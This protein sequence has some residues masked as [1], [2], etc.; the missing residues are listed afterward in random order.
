MFTRPWSEHSTLH[1]ML[2]LLD[3]VSDALN[4]KKFTIAIFC[5]LRKAFDTC[6]HEILLGKLKR[7]GVDGPELDWFKSYLSGRRQFISVGGR[8]KSRL[9]DIILGVPQGSILGPL[10]FLIYIN[11]LPLASEL[12][13]LLF[14]D[15]TT[16]MV[17]DDNL[18]HLIH[19]VNTEFRK[20]CEF[21]RANKLVIH[22][23]KT[24]FILFT[25]KNIGGRKIEIFSIII[26]K[27]RT[28]HLLSTQLIV[29]L[30]KVSK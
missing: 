17:L 30:K 3:K 10:L 13:A 8:T 4:E 21:F 19:K 24:N 20:I 26:M 12:L 18:D 16:L 5:D 14:A 27:I 7:Y 22:P 11:D 6:D 1:P 15:D 25:T 28:N 2:H 9:L 29:S 23:N